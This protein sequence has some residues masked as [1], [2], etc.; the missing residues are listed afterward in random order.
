VQD[1]TSLLVQS[2]EEERQRFIT[3]RERLLNIGE[4]IPLTV[5]I[6]S[7]AAL[8]E[9]PYD[10]RSQ[11]ALIYASVISHLRQ[12]QPQSACFLNRNSKD[13]DSP[14]IVD[15]LQRFSCRMIPRLDHGYDFL[16]SNL[17]A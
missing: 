7:E 10:L 16:K 12:Y 4:I 5:E 3:Y 17:L 13:F 6:L 14:D 1:I 11:D 2:N 8:Y 15:E 9:A